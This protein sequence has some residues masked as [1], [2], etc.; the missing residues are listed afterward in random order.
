VLV[1]ELMNAETTS[2]WDR[3]DWSPAKQTERLR[4]ELAVFLPAR[5]PVV[6]D[7]AGLW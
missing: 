3:Y 2:F 5:S 1:G 4:D 7:T 6:T